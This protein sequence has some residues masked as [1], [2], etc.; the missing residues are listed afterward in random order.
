MSFFEKLK[1]TLKD[2]EQTAIEAYRELIINVADDDGAVSEKQALTV[3][4]AAGKTAAEFEADVELERNKRIWRVQRDA[5]LKSRAKMQQLEAAGAQLIADFEAEIKAVRE[6]Y[7]VLESSNAL[8]R[9]KLQQVVSA[10]DRASQLLA[11]ACRDPELNA[12]L[13]Q[14]A[15]HWNI[16][17]GSFEPNDE[18][19]MQI[20]R[21][22]QS[23]ERLYREMEGVRK[24]IEALCG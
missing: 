16:A 20:E 6:K 10:G 21:S 3:L 8:E 18:S 1:A 5:G 19:E 11:E 12:R 22:H 13:A 14:L 17:R 23:A 4:E 2:R 15:R 7:A 9:S 24:Q